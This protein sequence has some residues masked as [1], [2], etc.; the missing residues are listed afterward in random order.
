MKIVEAKDFDN[1]ISKGTVFV[2]FYADWCGPCKMM[3]PIVEEVEKELTDISF[4]KVNV[5]NAEEIA[6]RYGIMSIPTFF[7]FK[8]GQLNKKMVGGHSKQEVVNFIKGN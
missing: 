4:I 3:G 1:E 6:M 8:E 7:L 2:D 5:D